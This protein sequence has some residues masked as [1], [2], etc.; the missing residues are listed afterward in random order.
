[1]I[2]YMSST[3]RSACFNDSLSVKSGRDVLLGD[4]WMSYQVPRLCGVDKRN[5]KKK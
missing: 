3:A 4:I 2:A 1:M 5:R